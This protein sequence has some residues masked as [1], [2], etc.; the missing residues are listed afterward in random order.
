M[1]DI[2]RDGPSGDQT[3]SSPSNPASLPG[4]NANTVPGAGSGTPPVIEGV[5]G[6][7]PAYPITLLIFELNHD[8]V[9]RR[10]EAMRHV[11]TIANALGPQR[12]RDEFIPYLQ[13]SVSDVDEVLLIL[14]EQLGTLLPYVG[15]PDHVE[16]LLTTLES[17]CLV[18]E[19][20]VRDAAVSA[21][22]ALARELPPTHLHFIMDLY[23]RLCVSEW[24]SSRSAAAGIVAAP[25]PRLPPDRRRLAMDLFKP[26]CDDVDVL[27]RRAA[28]RHIAGIAKVVGD[29]GD[30]DALLDVVFP[31]LQALTTDEH[32][33]VRLLGAAALGPMLQA[34]LAVGLP[35]EDA[36]LRVTALVR[37]FASARGWRVRY[38][39]ADAVPTIAPLLTTR[40]ASD[41]AITVYFG[42]LRDHEDEVVA[43]AA[44]RLA[45]VARVM[46]PAQVEHELLPRCR[47]LVEHENGLIK[48]AMSGALLH[49]G[50]TVDASKIEPLL[51]HLLSDSELESRLS[52]LRAAKE[53]A[54]EAPEALAP[55]VDEVLL[56]G[57]EGHPTQWRVRLEVI[58]LL[59]PMAQALGVSQFVRVLPLLLKLLGD[60]IWLVRKEATKALAPLT[61]VL[62][63]SWAAEHIIPSVQASLAHASYLQRISGAYAVGVL[64]TV[65]PQTVTVQTML[66]LMQPLLEDA[67]PNPRFVACK[68]LWRLTEDDPQTYSSTVHGLVEGLRHDP[69][70]EVREFATRAFL[71]CAAP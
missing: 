7:D 9:Q 68:V 51:G 20:T 46:T 37:D 54:E 30:R 25:Y 17:V 36:D 41:D 15:G 43:A 2:V 57:R 40:A 33:S 60:T 56:L 23:R 1:T 62:G 66:P 47:Q 67:V 8:E 6:E 61:R 45:E 71:A 24:A 38:V 22:D 44:G 65:L 52:F 48:S 18:E 70:K 29:A 49:L 14:A 16:L 64:A 39:V 13:D 5:S 59:A 53:L 28:C 31:C 26:L 32:D 12:T 10:I 69:D 3:S 19:S 21:I 35:A 63:D 55:F 27:V 34:L 42:L 58:P 4:Q 50:A 11:R